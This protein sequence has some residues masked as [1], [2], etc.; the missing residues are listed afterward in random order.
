MRRLELYKLVLAACAA[1]LLAWGIRA[2][3]QGVRWAG[4]ALLAAAFALRFV[5]RGRKLD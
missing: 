2:D 4:I 3:S 5:A 1:V